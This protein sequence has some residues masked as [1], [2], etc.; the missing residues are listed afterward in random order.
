MAAAHQR[1][2]AIATLVS[3]ARAQGVPVVRVQ[4]SEDGLV[5]GTAGWEHV[6]EL[7]RAGSEPLVHKNYGDSFVGTELEQVL[8]AAGVGRLIVAGAETDACICSTIHGVFT[9]GYDVNLVSDAHTAGDIP[10]WG[11]L[12]LEMAIADVNPYRQLQSTPGRTA[13]V[14]ALTEVRFSG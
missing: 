2:A 12:P 10:E 6:P 14:V 8:A 9:R 3:S 1:I 4:H 11:A 13:V 5:Q 7:V